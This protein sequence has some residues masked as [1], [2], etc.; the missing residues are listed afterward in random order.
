MKPFQRMCLFPNFPAETNSFR[1][2]PQPFLFSQLQVHTFSSYLHSLLVLIAVGQEAS[3][4]L[5]LS[6]ITE[7]LGFPV[8]TL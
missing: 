1:L 3:I 5:R 7:W 2:K 4:R 6:V 8:V